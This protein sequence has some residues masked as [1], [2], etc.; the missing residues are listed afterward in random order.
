[1]WDRGLRGLFPAEAP[2]GWLLLPGVSVPMPCHAMPARS[3][4]EELTSAVFAQ[5]AH[6]ALIE[7]GR[8]LQRYEGTRHLISQLE[9]LSM[10]Q[11]YC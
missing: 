9:I 1:M 5:S 7:Q 4:S 10:G 6:G 8:W 3:A 11:S 2:Y